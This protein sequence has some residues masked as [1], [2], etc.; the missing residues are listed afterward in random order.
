MHACACACPCMLECVSRAHSV[1][2]GDHLK[3]EI[4]PVTLHPLQ[5]LL[6]RVLLGSGSAN[7]LQPEAHHNNHNDATLPPL[8]KTTSQDVL[9]FKE[10]TKQKCKHRK[11]VNSSIV[12]STIIKKV[13]FPLQIGVSQGAAVWL[14]LYRRT[15]KQNEKRL[16]CDVFDA[17]ATRSGLVYDSTDTDCWAQSGSTHSC[18]FTTF[19][20]FLGTNWTRN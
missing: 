18:V 9:F 8:R 17:F 10:E 15:I 12:L 20:F 5:R 3:A 11:Y 2:V 14:T 16:V 19:N 13:P 4:L 6:Q 1:S 7:L